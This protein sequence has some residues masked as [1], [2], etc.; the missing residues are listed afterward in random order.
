MYRRFLLVGMTALALAACNSDSVDTPALGDTRT[1]L[2]ATG[3]LISPAAAPGAAFVP[4]N[5]GLADAPGYIA[6]QPVSEA[7]SPDRKTLLV[8]TSGYNNVLDAN[9]KMIKPDS[10][11]YVFVFDV[12]G[13]APVRKQV[14]QVSDTYVGIAFA[15]DGQHFYVTGGGDDN[16]HRFAF[17]QGAWGEVG[18]PIALNHKAGNGIGSTPL[19]TG[20]DVTA[21]GKR[22]VV[23][24]GNSA[25]DG[26]L[27]PR[28]MSPRIW[29]YMRSTIL[30]ENQYEKKFIPSASS[31]AIV[32]PRDP[33]IMPP[34]TMNRAV[35]AAISI[36]VLTQLNMFP[37]PYPSAGIAPHARA[38][39]AHDC[40]R[41]VR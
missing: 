2:L 18:A 31:N 6:G 24:S 34:I 14:L 25:S 13:G 5:P 21:D 35:I 20:V 8:L 16:L 32:I 39:A 10:N 27:L 36:A 4:L 23:A 15:P 12:S 19:A 41:S 38:A 37:T 28:P 3:Q 17:S 40:K 1:T 33:P 29:L 26:S 11:E 22:A 30:S 7:L 9:G